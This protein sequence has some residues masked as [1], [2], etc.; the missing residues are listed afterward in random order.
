MSKIKKNVGRPK[1]YENE[2][3]RKNARTEQFRRCKQKCR[4]R[5][6][7]LN[8]QKILKE[9]KDLKINTNKRSSDY[10]KNLSDFFGGFE[11]DFFITVTFNPDIV[12]Y[13]SY[14]SMKNYS[15]GIMEELLKENRLVRYLLTIEGEKPNIHSHIYL[16]TTSGYKQPW[17][18]RILNNRF[19]KGFVHITKE[20]IPISYGLKEISVD[21][22]YPENMRKFDLWDFG[23]DFTKKP[24]KTKKNQ[25]VLK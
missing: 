25:N 10:R 8:E 4:K 9:Q 7:I 13:V 2:E 20:K 21:T 11:Y 12:E 22:Q 23:G 14:N 5:D 17:F 3:D 24:I 18:T 16:K 15:F 6:K 19:K 1:K